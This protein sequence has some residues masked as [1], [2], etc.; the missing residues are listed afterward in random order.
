[1][2]TIIRH[3]LAKSQLDFLIFYISFGLKSLLSF[4]SESI[5]CLSS[6]PFCGPGIR[7]TYA[8]LNVPQR[9]ASSTLKSYTRAAVKAAPNASPVPVRSTTGPSKISKNKYFAPSYAYDPFGSSVKTQ[10]LTPSSRIADIRSLISDPAGKP[11]TRS[12]S[13][14]FINKI[15]QQA[16]SGFNASKPRCI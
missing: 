2:P 1:M 15:S 9:I 7:I 12:Y 16:K 14:L 6:K 3:C 11:S 4:K 13:S 8:E 5:S 10:I